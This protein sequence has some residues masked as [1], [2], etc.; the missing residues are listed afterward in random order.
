MC[1]IPSEPSESREEYWW[2]GGGGDTLVTHAVYSVK[3]M[4]FVCVCVSAKNDRC[5]KCASSPDSKGEMADSDSEPLLD[6]DS[7]GG[8]P[9]EVDFSRMVFLYGKVCTYMYMYAY[10]GFLSISSVFF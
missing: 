3:C 9:P 10:D 5:I 1:D 7:L 2:E 6:D 8:N 4:Y